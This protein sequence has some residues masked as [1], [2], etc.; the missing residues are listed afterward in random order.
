MTTITITFRGD[1]PDCL[2]GFALKDDVGENKYTV[3]INPIFP[4]D[5]QKRTFGHEM[6]HVLL[7]HCDIR[8]NEVE[9]T[10]RPISPAFEEL[11]EN[12]ARNAARAVF[13]HYRSVFS[14]AVQAAP[15]P[16]VLLI[17]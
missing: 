8:I 16:F 4:L 1:M 15:E 14:Q 9:R 7:E 11:M 17:P 10:G 6:G 13:K 5:E 12:E 2:R 3:C